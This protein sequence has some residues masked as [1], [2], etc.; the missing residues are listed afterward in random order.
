MGHFV[1][2]PHAVNLISNGVD[3]QGTISIPL[4]DGNWKIESVVYGYNYSGEKVIAVSGDTNGRIELFPSSQSDKNISAVVETEATSF[5]HSN[6]VFADV[7]AGAI[8]SKFAKKFT[9]ATSRFNF[10]DN[11]YS[12][13]GRGY[14]LYSRWFIS[15][16]NIDTPFDIP[17]RI[18]IPYN[19]ID[20]GNVAPADIRVMGRLKGESE[21]FL[22][23]SEVN[24]ELQIVTFVLD[25]QI[26]FAL[27]G[28]NEDVPTFR[29]IFAHSY[30]A[31]FTAR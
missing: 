11:S 23:E 22:I 8:M 26:E 3:A 7:P 2:W 29:D 18:T 19:D 10:H 9:L 28:P 27:V 12:M 16:S 6:R 14:F 15:G 1:T 4:V 24:T 13:L 20:L 21:T 5:A 31:P 25:R 30:Y 17:I